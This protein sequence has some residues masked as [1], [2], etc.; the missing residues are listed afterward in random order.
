MA[1]PPRRRGHIP[2]DRQFAVCKARPVKDI[3]GP[4][5]DPGP[6]IPVRRTRTHSGHLSAGSQQVCRAGRTNQHEMWVNS[7]G[8]GQSTQQNRLWHVIRRP[9]QFPAGE[10]HPYQRFG[11]GGMADSPFTQLIQHHTDVCADLPG[12]APAS[13][14]SAGSASRPAAC[15]VQDPMAETQV[16]PYDGVNV[17][18]AIANNRSRPGLPQIH[19]DRGT[20]MRVKSVNRTVSDRGDCKRSHQFPPLVHNGQHRPGTA[21]ADAARHPVRTARRMQGQCHTLVVVVPPG[22][23][24]ERISGAPRV[25][26]RRPAARPDIHR[27]PKPQV[28]PHPSIQHPADD[29]GGI[30]AI[31]QVI[32]RTPDHFGEQ[33]LP[34]VLRQVRGGCSPHPCEQADQCDVEP[35]HTR[36]LRAVQPIP[37]TGSSLRSGP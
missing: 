27:F 11:C 4:A 29:G 22:A 23:A 5:G 36:I 18:N 31:S 1:R 35:R 8:I 34:F 24:H 19:R 33:H 2:A 37:A 21:P 25:R 32:F 28:S 13:R 30:P 6:D 17:H 26:L 12:H 10:V 14:S 7:S 15:A 9:S 3:A 16:Q 20:A